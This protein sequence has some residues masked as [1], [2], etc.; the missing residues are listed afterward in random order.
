MKQ[1]A[2]RVLHYAFTA[3]QMPNSDK[4]MSFPDRDR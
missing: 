4:Y 2:D 3:L 1:T